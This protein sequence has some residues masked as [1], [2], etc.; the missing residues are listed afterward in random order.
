MDECSDNKRLHTLVLGYGNVDR[1]DDGLGY[2]VVNE[3]AQR[4]AHVELEPYGD[5]P[6]MV[7]DGIGLLFQRQLMPEMAE[8]LAQFERVVFV[9]AHTGAFAEELRAVRVEPGYAPQSLTHHLSPETLLYLTKVM[10]GCCPS[11]YLYSARGYEFDFCTQL[12]KR[13]ATLA[14]RVVDDILGMIV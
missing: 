14:E 12:S 6:T 8:L 3:I 13:T 11:A 9:D 10:Y 4:L 5:A 2:H 1:G 7:T